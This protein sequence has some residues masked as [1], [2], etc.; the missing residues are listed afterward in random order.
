MI[1]EV[2]AKRG[3]QFADIAGL[4][5]DPGK[6]D[7]AKTHDGITLT[8]AGYCETARAFEKALGLEEEPVRLEV[9]VKMRKDCPLQIDMRKFVTTGLAAGEY[10]LTV[11]DC[12]KVELGHKGFE[13]G[14]FVRPSPEEWEQI[15]KLRKLIVAKN[16]LYFHRW[17]P[18]NV[19]YLTGFRKH[20]QGKNARE[21]PQ[22]DPLVEAKEKEI[23]ILAW[24]RTLKLELKPAKK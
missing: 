14:L 9:G 18:Q 23:A 20:E 21:I 22:F 2:A 15:K 5:T 8:A 4:I 17:R 6:G 11:D 7:D 10:T 19:T 24:P 12:I 13:H 3:H 16:Q 1:R